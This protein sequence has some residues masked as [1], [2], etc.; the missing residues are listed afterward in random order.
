MIWDGTNLKAEN[1]DL[2]HAIALLLSISVCR[3]PILDL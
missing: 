1:P 2:L 3:M